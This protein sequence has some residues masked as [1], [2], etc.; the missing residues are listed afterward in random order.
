M[1][2]HRQSVLADERQDAGLGDRDAG[3]RG[4]RHR[5]VL[6]KRHV[7][8][9]V[10]EELDD[11]LHAADFDERLRFRT[12]NTPPKLPPAANILRSMSLSGSLAL[13]L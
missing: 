4:E 7:D 1:A 9:F 6:D 2:A 10:V 8:G 5:R 3:Q 11:P 13:T 12:T